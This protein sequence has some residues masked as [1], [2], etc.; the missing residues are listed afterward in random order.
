M[1]STFQQN[2]RRS[3]RDDNLFEI[4]II[5]FAVVIVV[6]I[7]VC[8][9]IVFVVEIDDIILLCCQ[10]YRLYSVAFVD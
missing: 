10:I 4:E 5:I 1:S 9:Y 7:H 3:Q 8:I 6:V 2:K